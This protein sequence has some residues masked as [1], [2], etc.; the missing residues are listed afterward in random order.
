MWVWLIYSWKQA[1]N[2]NWNPTGFC[3]VPAGPPGR[4]FST[5]YSSNYIK[6]SPA[7]RAVARSPGRTCFAT[8]T[9]AHASKTEFGGRVE[10][11]RL[12]VGVPYLNR[13]GPLYIS[14]FLVNVWMQSRSLPARG[15]V[16]LEVHRCLCI[17][18][19]G[20]VFISTVMKLAPRRRHIQGRIDTV[21]RAE[22]RG[23][24][25]TIFLV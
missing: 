16:G 3:L 8:I 12:E 4:Y 22:V 7:S 23:S 14:C 6:K 25:P 5:N 10:L 15:R 21:A 18:D 19:V 13:G 9:A 24:A 1:R 20:N 2:F 17:I 11:T